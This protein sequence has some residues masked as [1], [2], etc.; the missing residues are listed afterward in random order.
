MGTNN[1]ELEALYAAAL[2][3]PKGPSDR[4]HPAPA[5]R[6]PSQNVSKR[7]SNPGPRMGGS[8]AF[9]SAGTPSVLDSEEDGGWSSDSTAISEID[10]DMFAEHAL[11]GDLPEGDVDVLDEGDFDEIR[12]GDDIRTPLPDELPLEV[13]L[14]AARARSQS[15]APPAPQAPAP[16][17]P[18]PTPSSK[19]TAANPLDSS[20]PTP[21]SSSS[22]GTNPAISASSLP[23]RSESSS[24]VKR[25]ASEIRGVSADTLSM[26][27]SIPPSAARPRAASVGGILTDQPV[28]RRGRAQPMYE[29][30][31]P[32][33]PARWQPPQVVDV[34]MGLVP[35]LGLLVRKRHVSAGILYVMGALLALLPTIL[36]L[37]TWKETLVSFRELSIGD[38]WLLP[39]AA[40]PVVSLLIFEALR[41][42]STFDLRKHKHVLARSLGVLALPSLVL[43]VLGAMVVRVEPGLVEPVWFIGAFTLVVGFIAGLYAFVDPKKGNRKQRITYAVIGAASALVLTV[44]ILTGHVGLDAL[45]MLASSSKAAGFRLLPSL[46]S[47]LSG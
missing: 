46:L 28:D 3:K 45:Q 32:P 22:S 27:M 10:P 23:A 26:T 44:L 19:L 37:S 1:D 8:A 29:P 6:D 30:K 9:G 38:F 7:T 36:V 24:G 18:P 4:N 42:L 31:S 40:V 20:R 34:L 41:A 15:F 39:L 14:A 17:V 16:F 12:E 43:V 47:A 5:S 11:S 21:A 2:A 25:R 13:R 33:P 35:G